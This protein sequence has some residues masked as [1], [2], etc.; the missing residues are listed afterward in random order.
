M[1]P[2]FNGAP[3]PFLIIQFPHPHTGWPGPGTTLRLA[4]GSFK[5]Y[6]NCSNTLLCIASLVHQVDFGIIIYNKVFNSC[7]N[8][9]HSVN[10]IAGRG[11]GRHSYRKV[12]TQSGVARFN[13][14]VC[15][16]ETHF[17]S[18]IKHFYHQSLIGCYGNEM[19][20]YC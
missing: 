3:R 20:D 4:L 10:I 5:L 17:I 7:C 14:T 19:N 15:N 13:S 12:A 8:S 2:G 18:K 1:I 16:H 11:K 9:S 6:A